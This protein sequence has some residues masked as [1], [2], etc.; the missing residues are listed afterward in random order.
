MSGGHS[1]TT[2]PPGGGR[3]GG[4]KIS[5]FGYA[6]LYKSGYEG[7]GGVKQ[8]KIF[9]HVVFEWPP[10][11]TLF[12][13]I[14]FKFEGPKQKNIQ[15]TNNWRTF[16]RTGKMIEK[17]YFFHEISVFTLQKRKILSADQW[18]VS[19]TFSAAKAASNGRCGQIGWV[20][21]TKFANLSN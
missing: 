7:G 21:E 6:H 3:G 18:K 9:G 10:G 12:Q 4:Q 17:K 13:I 2:K 14:I 1:K 16:K 15:E 5:N 19:L 8:S 11:W 20:I